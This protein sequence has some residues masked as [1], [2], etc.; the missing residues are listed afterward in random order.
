MNPKIIFLMF[1]VLIVAGGIWL[2]TSPIMT[3]MKYEKDRIFASTTTTTT[4]AEVN[5]SY[6]NISEVGI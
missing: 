6:E 5:A 4:I 1:A 2:F 3:P